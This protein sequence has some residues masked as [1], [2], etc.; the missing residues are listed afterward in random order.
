M[1]AMVAGATDKR[2]KAIRHKHPQDERADH[3]RGDH[4]E[5]YDHDG[6]SPE[7]T[8]HNVNQSRWDAGY[9]THC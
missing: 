1:W 5:F 3:Q 2:L 9:G 4:K 6:D 8:L 7:E